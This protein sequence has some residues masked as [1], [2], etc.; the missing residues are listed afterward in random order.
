LVKIML[1]PPVL[2]RQGAKM[3]KVM[4]P[5]R[6]GAQPSIGITFYPLG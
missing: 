4:T 5:W 3:M 1:P 6:H 2:E